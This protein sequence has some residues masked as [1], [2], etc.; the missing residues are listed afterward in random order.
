MSV[1]INKVVDV[2]LD[3]GEH[4]VAIAGDL[5][6]L[7]VDHDSVISRDIPKNVCKENRNSSE[8]SIRYHNFACSDSVRKL[9]FEQQYPS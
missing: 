1:D 2:L 7:D 8:K 3:L 4:N 6:I 5:V 9:I